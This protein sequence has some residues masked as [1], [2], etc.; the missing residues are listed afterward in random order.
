MHNCTS[1]SSWM[2][3]TLFYRTRLPVLSLYFDVTGF[4]VQTGI[5]FLLFFFFYYILNSQNWELD[6]LEFFNDLTFECKKTCILKK[7]KKNTFNTNY[8]IFFL[9]PLILVGC[10][11]SNIL[12]TRDSVSSGYP[13]K[14][15][16]VE[17]MTCSGLF[18]T[19]EV[20]G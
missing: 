2:S 13:N 9:I 8:N 1:F 15:K 14:K 5:H 17:N 7:K 4:Y 12:W 20:I 3:L 16:R 11:T 6:A 19:F 18:L 10:P